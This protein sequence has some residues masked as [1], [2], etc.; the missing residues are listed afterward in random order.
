MNRKK[1]P[2][3]GVE[4]PTTI[5]TGGFMSATRSFP[6]KDGFVMVLCSSCREAKARVVKPYVPIFTDWDPAEFAERIVKE[7]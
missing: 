7:E 3:C 5:R 1:C 4:A 6:V 2:E